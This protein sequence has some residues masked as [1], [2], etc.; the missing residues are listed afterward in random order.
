MVERSLRKAAPYEELTAF[1][2]MGK[3]VEFNETRKV[4]KNTDDLQ[5]ERYVSGKFG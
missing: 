2:M 1:M 4:F 5:T 3:L